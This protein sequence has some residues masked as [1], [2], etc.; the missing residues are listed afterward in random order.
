M[1]IELPLSG[2]QARRVASSVLD[3]PTAQGSGVARA[4]WQRCAVNCRARRL[5]MEFE[6]RDG[7]LQ[8]IDQEEMGSVG[9]WHHKWD[10]RDRLDRTGLQRLSAAH[11]GSLQAH[12]QAARGPLALGKCVQ[13]AFV[14]HQ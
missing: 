10:G 5:G 7:N 14:I 3:R 6:R 12:G 11:V 9:K 13:R 8:A 1:T 2:V 4:V